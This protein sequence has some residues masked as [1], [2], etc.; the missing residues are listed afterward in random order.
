[1]RIWKVPV[2]QILSA[3]GGLAAAVTITACQGILAN[4]S[5]QTESVQAE[6]TVVAQATPVRI[7]QTAPNFSGVDSNGA[8]RSLS[9]FRGKTVVLEWTNHQCPFTG[10]HYTSGNMQALQAEATAQGIVWL[11]IISSAPGQQGYVTATE[12]NQLTTSRNASPTAVILDPEGE[13]GRLYSARTTPHMYVIDPQGKLR[14]MGGI[15]N[16]PSAD[17]SD[18]A[19]ATNYVQA[20]LASL[21]SG[22]TVD[23]E[24]TQPYGCSIKYSL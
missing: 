15:D 8:T 14:Y 7:S 21:S 18:V 13:I 9:D 11:S 12:A 4:P 5:N 19:S 24:V 22:R 2:R 16:I 23:P 20:A 17:P 6:Q 10:K 1:M 3:G